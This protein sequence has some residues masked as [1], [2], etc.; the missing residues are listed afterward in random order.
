[1]SKRHLDEY[2]NKIVTD[3]KEMLDTI[4]ELEEECNK[5][6]VHPDKLEQIKEAV[7]PLKENYMTL[8]W[9]MFLLNKPNRKNKSKRYE[10]SEK[11]KMKKIDPKKER[12]PES[13]FKENKETIENIKNI[14]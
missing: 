9:V 5:G 2:F 10:E 4:K 1:M 3:Y 8:S 12:S 14:F 13:V 6:L 7:K 11:N